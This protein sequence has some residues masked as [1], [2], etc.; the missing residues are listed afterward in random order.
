MNG[1]TFTNSE[2]FLRYMQS[3][4]GSAN[5]ARWQSL[6]Y[7]FY[8]YVAYAD[9]GQLVTNFFGFAR[10]GAAGQNGQYTNMVK[11]GSFGQN[12]FLLKGIYCDYY[13]PNAARTLVHTADT[14]TA[15]S[16]IVHGFAQAGVLQLN[17]GSKPYVQLPK[18]FLY[19]PPADGVCTEV[20][21][22]HFTFTLTEGTPN[23]ILTGLMSVAHADLNR[24]Q[25]AGYIVDPNILIEA[26]QAFECTIQ[27]PSG[28]VPV[29]GTS[30]SALYIGVI[31]DGILFRPT[32]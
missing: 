2:Q 21:A 31:L 17:I 20:D 30:E 19:A 26:E 15:Y 29:I 8:S 1:V 11:A 14:S 10:T 32:Q 27:Y 16:D 5:F 4:Y 7:Q 28:L 23:T 24:N 6:R 18:P 13:I 22:K 9:A 12:H 3:K 25:N